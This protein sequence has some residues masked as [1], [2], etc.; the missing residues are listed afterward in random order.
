MTGSGNSRR[1]L[2]K[3]EAT[4]WTSVFLQERPKRGFSSRQA[5]KTA[6]LDKDGTG[7]DVGL[8]T[9]LIF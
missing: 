1:Y 4:A 6:A 5:E 2:F 7:D 9:S 8:Q 3:R